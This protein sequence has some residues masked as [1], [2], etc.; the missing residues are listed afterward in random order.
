MRA[1]VCEQTIGL[2]GLALRE[3]RDPEPGACHVRIDVAAAGVNFADLL[4]LR[5]RYQE[6][7]PLP[8]VP[9]LEIAGTID[10]VGAGAVMGGVEPGQRVLAFLDHGG[11]AEKTLA[12]AED[13][14]PIPDDV[15][16][17]T[18][19]AIAITYGTAFGA[20]SWRAQLLPGEVL[21]VHGAAGGVGL[22]AV[23]VGKA[24][25]AKVIATARGAERAALAAEHGADHALDSEDPELR[26]RIKD[27]TGG[28]GVDVVFDPVGGAMFDLSLR[29][30]A[31]EG[32][33]VVVGFASGEIPQIPAN[34]LLVK[35]AAALGFFWGSY[36]KHD[37][38]RLRES[39]EKIFD[40]LERGR[41]RPHVSD[42]IP[43]DRGCDALALVQERRSTGKVVVRV[44]PEPEPPPYRTTPLVRPAAPGRR[45]R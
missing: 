33:I 8:F 3:M 42:V 2:E 35:N 21:L 43:L 15:D 39:F 12:R 37:P 32:R 11:F 28:R 29:V 40:W 34:I 5:G 10:K 9:G 22:A 13:V 36:R 4:M 7:P 26:G 23:E 20:L 44:A 30:I 18:A 24:M 14:I 41:I 6:R 16:D 45:Q 27:L 25:G 31:W 1:L 19:A 17:I 38:G